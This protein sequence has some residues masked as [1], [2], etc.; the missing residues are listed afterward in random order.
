MCVN[1]YR[2]DIL[3]VLAASR[4]H[5][6][7]NDILKNHAKN[8]FDLVDKYIPT[9]LD[10]MVAIKMAEWDVIKTM[11]KRALVVLL[12]F[13]SGLYTN[14]LTTM[15][16]HIDF[17]ERSGHPVMELIQ[18]NP[19]LLNEESVEISNAWLSKATSHDS[20]RGDI[21]LLNREYVLQK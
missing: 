18:Q 9:F 1:N 19:F 8:L 14:A 15:L 12:T 7:Q 6:A 11:L 13:E 10:Y 4:D 17:L 5:C 3:P 16:L 20:R 21:D 2:A